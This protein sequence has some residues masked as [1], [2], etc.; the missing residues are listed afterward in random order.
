[1]NALKHQWN[2]SLLRNYCYIASIRTWALCMPT[3]INKHQKLKATYSTCEI[4]QRTWS[5]VDLKHWY[6]TVVNCRYTL[7]YECN[8]TCIAQQTGNPVNHL[9][10]LKLKQN[11]V[12]DPSYV[13][14][15]MAIAVYFSLKI[16][17]SL[18]ETNSSISKP[19]CA[20][21]SIG[22]KGNKKIKHGP[23]QQNL[24]CPNSFLPFS[25]MEAQTYQ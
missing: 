2:H 11:I 12:K 13:T 23:N 16:N 17:F 22:S 15:T 8:Y 4:T 24:K 25:N 20:N 14:L 21:N 6:P 10:Q 18:Q 9:V 7:R 19:A 5:W 1:M 3:I